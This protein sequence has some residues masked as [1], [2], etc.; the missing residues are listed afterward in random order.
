MSQP[1]LQHMETHP[2]NATQ[3]PGRIVLKAKGRIKRCTKAQMIADWQRKLEASKAS[4]QAIQQGHQH[5][6]TFQ[7]QIT[8]DQAAARMDAPK[9][10]HPHARPI[11]KAVKLSASMASEQAGA[12]GVATDKVVGTKDKRGGSGGML[13][14]GANIEN[15]ARDEELE[16]PLPVK[17]RSKKVL[18]MPVRDA[19]QTA[20]VVG[21]ESLINP[22]TMAHDD[23]TSKFVTNAQTP[24]ATVKKWRVSGRISGWMPITATS[25]T[26]SCLKPPSMAVPSMS[27]EI[28]KFTAPGSASSSRLMKESTIS[29]NSAPPLTPQSTAPDPDDGADEDGDYE[30]NEHGFASEVQIKASA[31]TNIKITPIALND[32]EVLQ[33]MVQHATI[34]VPEQ[35]DATEDDDTGNFTMLSDMEEDIQAHPSTYPTPLVNYASDSDT[36]FETPLFAQASPTDQNSDWV[37]PSLAQP[38]STHYVSPAYYI[39]PKNLKCK[40][41]EEDLVFPSSEIEILDGPDKLSAVLVK[42]EPEPVILWQTSVTR[43]AIKH[44]APM[45][46]RLKSSAAGT[47]SQACMSIMPSQAT[48]MPRI[49]L[50]QSQYRMKHLPGDEVWAIKDGPL[51]ASLQLIWDAVYKGVSYTVTTD[52]PVIAVNGRNSLGTTALVVF[53]NFLRSQPDLKTDEDREQFSACLLIKSAFLFGMIKDD[54]SKHTEPFQSDLIV[55]VLTQHHCTI[56]GALAFVPGIT[57]LGHMKGALGLATSAAGIFTI[58]SYS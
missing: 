30:S 23:Q 7:E 1:A 43:I 24:H 32:K 15:P 48:E 16:V 54:S 41:T 55:Q 25:N 20:V 14:A 38:P 3:Y 22:S 11:T 33:N 42:K 8:T 39:L 53:A 5:I 6:A 52:G 35:L 21:T 19:I 56:S 37:F 2:K 57:T 12:L 9:P 13:A 46:K 17:G 4:E 29:Y 40:L 34:L 31:G 26:T 18:K 58:S 28:Q 44:K 49:M 45:A 51:S 27:S 36:D 50:S 47:A 10:K